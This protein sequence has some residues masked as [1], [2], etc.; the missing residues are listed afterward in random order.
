MSQSSLADA[1]VY[2]GS[3]VWVSRSVTLQRK[4]RDCSQPI[5]L[6]NEEKF[7]CYTLVI[8]PIHSVLQKRKMCKPL[9]IPGRIEFCKADRTT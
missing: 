6:Y 8:T 7:S 4:I 3:R 1:L 9:T 2:R 5:I